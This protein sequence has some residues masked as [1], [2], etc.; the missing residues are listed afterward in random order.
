MSYF[1]RLSKER[2]RPYSVSES[3]FSWN[4][5]NQYLCKSGTYPYNSNIINRLEPIR[6]WTENPPV[7]GSIP[8]L[9]ARRKHGVFS[10]KYAIEAA[11]LF[12]K[13]TQ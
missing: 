9:N 1:M 4:I 10:P 3:N 2:N 5:T 13:C 7:G 6:S 11:T 12:Q 8:S